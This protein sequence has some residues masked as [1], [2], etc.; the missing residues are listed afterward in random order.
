MRNLKNFFRGIAVLAMWIG[1]VSFLFGLSP[2]F[3]DLFILTQVIFAHIFI[4]SPW[5]SPTFKIPV[6]GM[7][8]VQFMAWLP[9]VARDG[10]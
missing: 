7:Q 6:S 5:L 1:L 10:I 8:F 9:D 2:A 3:D 4:Q